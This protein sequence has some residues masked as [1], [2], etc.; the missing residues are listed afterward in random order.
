VLSCMGDPGTKQINV[1]VRS[2][3]ECGLDGICKALATMIVPD[4]KPAW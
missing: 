3:Q 2:R 1:Y 4:M